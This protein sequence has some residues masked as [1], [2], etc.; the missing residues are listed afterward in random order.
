MHRSDPNAYERELLERA[1]EF[2]GQHEGAPPTAANVQAVAAERGAEFATAWLYQRL[3][4]SDANGDF[5]EQIEAASDDPGALDGVDAKLV[6]VPGAF[7]REFPNSG[8]DGRLLQETARACGLEV[9]VIPTHS[10]GTLEAN[11]VI[12]CN[13]LL[14][15][16]DRPLILASLCKGGSD[17]KF[18]LARAEA[19]DA[20][21]NVKAWISLSGIIYGSPMANWALASPIR[22]LWYRLLL[23]LQGYDFRIVR[24]LDC[25]EGAP[26]SADLITTQNLAMIHVVG[27]PL[28]HHLTTALVRRCYNRVRRLGPNDGGGMLLADACRLPGYVYPVWGADHYLRPAQGDMPRLMRAILKAVLGRSQFTPA[29]QSGAS[30]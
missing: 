15:Q 29:R 11:A 26:L 27:F 6:I 7:Y 5:I 4:M 21:R 13:W 8:A 22:R 14:R 18:A 19:P 3:R 16:P 24:Q 23:K 30:A 28:V 10:F 25:A 17:V 2:A 12:V 20:F 1:A 9:A